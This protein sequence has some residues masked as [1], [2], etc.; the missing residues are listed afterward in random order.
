MFK[1]VFLSL[2]L[3]I[4]NIVLYS[5]LYN[6]INII[7]QIILF[8]FY[9]IR[10]IKFIHLK[11][12]FDKYKDFI[13]IQY[14]NNDSNDYFPNKYFNADSFALALQI[15]ILILTILNSEIFEGCLIKEKYLRKE[16]DQKEYVIYSMI[17]C[18]VLIYMTIIFLIKLIVN[19][20]RIKFGKDNILNNWKNNPIKSISINES[21]NEN[22]KII[23]KNN[24]I[25]FEK[26]S[27]YNYINIL[28]DN[29][30]KESKICGKDS[31][32]ND[33]YFPVDI[34]CPINSLIITDDENFDK[35]N[36]YIKLTLKDNSFLY[37]T[38]KKINEKIIINLIIS[39]HNGPEL[40]FY[41]SLENDKLMDFDIKSYSNIEKFNKEY[42]LST[43]YIGI[44]SNILPKT[45]KIKNF[46][47]KLNYYKNLIISIEA[48]LISFYVIIP[49]CRCCM[50]N[51]DFYEKLNIFLIVFSIV[52]CIF[53]VPILILA[54]VSLSMNHQYVIN[55]LN[56]INKTYENN[57]VNSSLET[58]IIIYIIIVIIYIT[59]TLINFFCGECFERFIEQIFECKL[60]ECG[61]C[62]IFKCDC[63]FGKCECFEC[64]KSCKCDCICNCFKCSKKDRNNNINHVPNIQSENINIKNIETSEEIDSLKSMISNMVSKTDNFYN[65]IKD[66]L[67]E[68]NN[69]ISSKNKPLNNIQNNKSDNDIKNNID[70][71]QNLCS[72]CLEKIRKNSKDI[73]N[74]KNEINKL[75]NE[76]NN[77]DNNFKGE[78]IQ[79]KNN[80]KYITEI[81]NDCLDKIK[82]IKINFENTNK[83]DKELKIII[84][85]E[86]KL[87]SII[88]EKDCTYKDLLNKIEKNVSS[89]FNSIDISNINLYYWNQFGKK[90]KIMN[91]NDFSHALSF[92]IFYFEVINEKQIKLRQQNYISNEDN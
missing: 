71:I 45:E 88:L 14:E 16:I 18:L 39:N 43:H 34:D 54:S 12:I 55:F 36:E 49:I 72:N 30:Y 58:A 79:L 42:L 4:M 67:E 27:D 91:E 13:S 47:D 7:I 46:D 56:K 29:K 1:F 8:I 3:M 92:Q 21:E 74:N 61:E 22:S 50:V 65:N 52:I 37:Y 23:W 64:L 32:D 15:N 77:M 9:L 35:K 83:I 41:E 40:N 19:L 26:L 33:L 20:N 17:F 6:I 2:A 5:N 84:K 68:I 44:D 24:S 78:I 85:Y 70:N 80:A 10:Y 31:N 53:F 73:N 48:L 11:N 75:Q 90:N 87:Y 38:N 60:C 28:Y 86:N 62:K 76:I 25:A 59:I 82:N 89:N 66:E 57:K 63:D 81:C 69:N 51:L